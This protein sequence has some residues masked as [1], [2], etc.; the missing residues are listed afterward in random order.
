MQ[1]TSKP[2]KQPKIR[3]EK[4]RYGQAP[5]NALPPALSDQA[6]VSPNPPLVGQAP[7]AAMGS[8][9]P[10]TIISTG[11]G[12]DNEDPLAPKSAPT[13]KTRIGDR[14]TE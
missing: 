8:M 13:R 10:T 5:R 4:V 14:H 9:E 2:V 1:N 12:A 6:E 11:T 7:G 3:R